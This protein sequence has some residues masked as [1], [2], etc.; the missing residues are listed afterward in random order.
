VDQDGNS[1]PHNHLLFGVNI[2]SN[3]LLMQGGLHDEND[4]TAIP[5]STSNFLSP[6]QHDFSLDQT[7][8]SPG[9]LDESGYVTC[10]Q[11]ADQGNQPPATFVKVL[12]QTFILSV[13]I[14]FISPGVSYIDFLLLA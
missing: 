14:L 9:C 13:T 11:N 4:S 12:C 3:S 1:D 8:N 6:S 2:D 5:Y 10:S 7:L